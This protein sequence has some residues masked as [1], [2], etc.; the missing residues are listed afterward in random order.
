MRKLAQR[1]ASAAK[2]IKL[3]I[4]DSVDKVAMGSQLVNQAGS[5]MDENVA[6]VK[7]VTDIMAD[8]ASATQEQDTGIEQVN[9]AIIEMD[10]VIQQNAALVEQAAAAAES[11]QDQ[12]GSL[13]QLVSVF[14]LDGDRQPQ[15]QRLAAQAGRSAK[16]TRPALV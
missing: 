7:R 13:A 10:T 9:R 5:T 2:E 3:L 4:G 15:P 11:L 1:S 6:S 14:K 12:A 8:I 16:S